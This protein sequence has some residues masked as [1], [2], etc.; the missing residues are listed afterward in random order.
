MVDYY[1]IMKSGIYQIRNINNNK[2]YIGSAVNLIKRKN[3]HFSALFK[4]KHEN[5]KLQNAYNK[6]GKETFIFEILEYCE[7]IDLIIK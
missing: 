1:T 7:V 4:N 5:N 2:L 3:G 6:Y